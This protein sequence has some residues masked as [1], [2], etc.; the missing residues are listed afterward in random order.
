MFLKE[1]LNQ[2]LPALK[3]EAELGNPDA[4][5]ILAAMYRDGNGVQKDLKLAAHYA[6]MERNAPPFDLPD[7]DDSNPW[8]QGPTIEV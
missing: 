8:M 4:M 7:D 3:K 1:T 2:W 6:E 5:A